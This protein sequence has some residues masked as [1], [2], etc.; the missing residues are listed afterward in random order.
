MKL[1]A[2]FKSWLR[3]L[4]YD[5]APRGAKISKN[6]DLSNQFAAAR[7]FRS[8]LHSDFTYHMVVHRGEADSVV[9]EREKV[10]LH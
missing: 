5:P 4:S 10:D 2:S 3:L 6:Y 1:D 8:N 9:S 7:E